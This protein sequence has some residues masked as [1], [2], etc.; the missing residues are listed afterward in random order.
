MKLFFPLF[1]TGLLLAV[2]S[3][4]ASG[5]G[6]DQDS[7]IGGA[8]ANEIRCKRISVTGSLARKNRVCKTNAEWE[9]ISRRENS[10]ARR[11]LDRNL[12][13]SSTNGK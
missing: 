7:S 5:S 10:E 1:A 11:M 13:G 6:T 8:D 4:A 2:P 9:R 3:A 12:E